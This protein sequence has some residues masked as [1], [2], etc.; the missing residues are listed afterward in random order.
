MAELTPPSRTSKAKLR[1]ALYKNESRH[2][3]WKETYRKVIINVCVDLL[4]N[5]TIEVLR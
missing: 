4:L 2:L 5:K 3:E 1:K